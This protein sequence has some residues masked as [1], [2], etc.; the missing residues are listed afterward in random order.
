[1]VTAVAILMVTMVRG[2][3]R[4]MEAA[5]TDA[6][7]MVDTVVTVTVDTVTTDTVDVVTIADDSTNR[8]QRKTC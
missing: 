7:V 4:I 5:D 1:M 8:I 2:I 6:T 3:H